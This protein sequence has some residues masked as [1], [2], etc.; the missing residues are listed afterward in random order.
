MEKQG[1]YGMN[2]RTIALRLLLLTYKTWEI[3]IFRKIWWKL[4]DLFKKRY[5]NK[6]T[7]SKI[8][9]FKISQP[10]NF[11]YP[12]TSR[13]FK[14]YNNPLIECVYQLSISKNKKINIF[15]VGAAIGDTVLLI[16]SNCPEMVSKFYCIEGDIE[17]YN[18]LT[19][20]MSP[21]HDV[22][23]INKIL[24]D[25][26]GKINN[27]V[28]IHSGTA[29][30]Q[31]KD[32]INANTFDEIVSSMQVEQLDL[33]KID[34]DG[35]DGRI[36]KGAENTINKFLPLIIF[37][38]HP[39]LCSQAKTDFKEHFSLLRKLDY[40]KFIWYTKFGEFSHFTIDPSDEY[41]HQFAEICINATFDADWHYDIIAIHNNASYSI[42]EFANSNY[43]RS[44]KSFY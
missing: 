10:F 31:G 33:I 27:L 18:Y 11:T 14:N 30:A 42:S 20:N 32:V 1:E 12:I 13:M 34:T 29:S 22:V 15:D 37:E 16:K 38:W 17:F 4:Y 40:T 6:F 36:L 35:Y 43:S 21:F 39:I 7:K 25:T 28:R 19:N 9:G 24:S 2:K 44:R 5:K 26:P 41:I 8:H 3:P 23:C